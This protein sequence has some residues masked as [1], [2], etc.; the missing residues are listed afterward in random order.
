[1][2]RGAARLAPTLVASALLALAPAV[3]ASPAPPAGLHI[4]SGE[5]WQPDPEFGLRWENPTADPPIV[6]IHYLLRDPAGIP[7]GPSTRI[8]AWREELRVSLSRRPPGAHEVEVWLEDGAGAQGPAASARLRYDPQAPAGAAPAHPFVRLSRTE[9]PYPLRLEHP[10][11]PIPLSGIRGYALSLGPDPDR[12]PCAA[13]DRCTRSETDLQDGVGGDTLTVA[14]LP[15]GVTHVRSV[16]VSGA[17]VRSEAVGHATFEVDKVDPRTTLDGVPDG[18]TNRPVHLTATAA[19]SGSGMRPAS[20]GSPFTAIRV[21]AAP[22]I[23]SSGD[24]ASAT[25]IEEG[26]HTV[27]HYA[28]DLAGNVADGG[29]SNGRPNRPPATA[30]VKIDRGPPQVGFV[31]ARFPADPELIEAR[32]IDPLS[33]PAEVGEIAFRAIGSAD[34]FV[35]L[36]T[37]AGPGHLRARWS[38]D[39]HPPGVYEFRATGF[40]LAGNTGVGTVRADGSKMVLPNPLKARTWISVGFGAAGGRDRALRPFGRGSLLTGRLS[41]SSDE[42]LAGLPIRIVERFDAGTPAGRVTTVY[43]GEDGWFSVHLP[44]GPGRELSAVFDGNRLAARSTGGPLRLGVRSSITLR[45][46]ARSARIGGRP[47]VLGGAVGADPGAMPDDGVPVHLQF[48]AAGVPW[49]TFRTI[50]AD[51]RGR[52]RLAYRFSDDDS[53]GVRF[54]FRAFVPPGRRWPYEPGGSRPVAV[55][56]I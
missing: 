23:V 48:R 25:V 32:V 5:D 7:L 45:S 26:V 10:P 27:A 19:D 8:P 2:I 42:S 35:P 40:D 51:R 37:T 22:P 24:I 12:L 9:L 46:S 53:R 36:R 11:G 39:D 30:L 15:E 1:M 4:A 14:E 18:W 44:P 50:Q 3:A 38:S 28:R 49:T 31:G 6:A 21:D 55:R 47:I 34:P 52:F 56:G 17:G 16:A 33:G 29:S 13:S 20:G 41:L 43:T 54:E